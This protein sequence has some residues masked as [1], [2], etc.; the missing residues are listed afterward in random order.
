MTSWDTSSS[1]GEAA[2]GAALVCCSAAGPRAT[3]EVRESQCCWLQ[4]SSQLKYMP[5]SW[6]GHS[7]T[8]GLGRPPPPPPPR[9]QQLP[10]LRARAPHG[11]AGAARLLAGAATHP[12]SLT[13]RACLR[14]T[15][16][17]WVV[18]LSAHLYVCPGGRAA[19]RCACSQP[20]RHSTYVGSC[21][22]T[23]DLC[24]GTLTLTS[25]A[26]T[27]TLYTRMHTHTP[28]QVLLHDTVAFKSLQNSFVVM[29]NAEKQAAQIYRRVLERYPTN[30]ACV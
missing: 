26:A 27:T 29:N 7:R 8:T 2:A 28:S 3:P 9:P 18:S 5:Y 1:S 20:G 6:A 12:L 16:E 17:G 30:G 23:P 22:A 14:V 13:C 25:G 21:S 15:R 4:P 19:L 11:A 10:R 24:S